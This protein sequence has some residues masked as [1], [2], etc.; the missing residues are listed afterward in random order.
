MFRLRTFAAGLA[1]ALT[2]SSAVQAA[3]IADYRGEYLAAPSNTMTRPSV[4]ADG[5]DYM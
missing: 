5:W 3:L 2:T 1:L 4:S